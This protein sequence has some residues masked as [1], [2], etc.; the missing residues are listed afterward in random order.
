MIVAMAARAAWRSKWLLLG[1]AV[2]LS[3]TLARFVAAGAAPAI[4]GA[5]SSP[6][7]TTGGGPGVTLVCTGSKW[8]RVT[9]GSSPQVLPAGTYDKTAAAGLTSGHCSGTGSTPLIPPMK[10]AQVSSIEPYGLMVGG[11]VTP[12]DHQYYNGTDPRAL[13][14]TYDVV[15]PAA[16][17][18]VSISH[19]G[20]VVNTPPRSVD[21]PSNDEYRIV[22]AHSCS[23]L[24]YV[25]LVTSLADWL[26]AKLPSGAVK[27]QM[28]LNSL[29][30]P[31]T[32]GQALGRIG[33]QTLDFAVWDLSQKPLAGLLVRKAYD[34]AEPW[35]P[36][37]APTS[38]YLAAKIRAQTLAKYLRTAAPVDGRIDYD[39]DGK[40]IGTWFQA[41]TD[42][43]AGTP[44]SRSTGYWA[45]QLAIAPNFLAPSLYVVSLGSFSGRG[46]AQQFGIKGNA[47]DPTRVTVATGLVKYE[48]VQQQARAADDSMVWTPKVGVTVQNGT[49]VVGVALVQLT[50]KRTLRVEIFP[51]K[52]AAEVTGF[53][54][55][56]LTF[57]RGDDAQPASGR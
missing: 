8:Q 36:F 38:R 27:P 23:F 21:I 10:L 13:R 17:R 31:V 29:D 12:I 11:H 6:G 32:Q 53:S 42:G 48:L 52:T 20:P 14:D 9:G 22:I 7:A 55:A 25:D 19:R 2:G 54:S 49:Q 24:T 34:N 4:G 15:A 44:A 35:K 30:I 57:G 45:G 47:P 1:L 5:C 40:L 28:N 51:G 46:D 3:L 18:I 26:K 33:G 50:A 41:G 37:T 56:A 39:R 16:G 43:Y